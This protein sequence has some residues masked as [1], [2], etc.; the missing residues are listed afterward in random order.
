MILEW[1]TQKN[2]NEHVLVDTENGK[3]IGRVTKMKETYY[4][5]YTSAILGE[6]VSLE[7]A[8]KAIENP[9]L[10]KPTENNRNYRI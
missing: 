4:A 5:F 6:Y 1:Q 3:I 2:G 8:K 10:L 7:F 9:S